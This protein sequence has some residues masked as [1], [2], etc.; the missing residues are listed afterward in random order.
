MLKL[1]DQKISSLYVGNQ[2]IKKAYL[3]SEIVFQEKP[4][5]LPAGY[6]EVEYIQ[7]GSLDKVDLPSVNSSQKVV[8]DVQPLAY[9]KSNE[10]LFYTSVHLSTGYKFFYM[11]RKSATSASITITGMLVKSGIPVTNNGRIII[12][13]DLP[14]KLVK[15]GSNSYSTSAYSLY[16]YGALG[17]GYNGTPSTSSPV[18]PAR[19]YSVKIYNGSELLYDYVPCK[20]PSGKIGMY[21]LITSTFKKG[22][23]G[24]GLTAGPAV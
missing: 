8:M 11:Q 6:T 22:T 19:W 17:L 3:G 13:I 5:R 12:D 14:Q 18:A 9:T 4:S 24:G 20:D 16:G 10:Y 23:N 1:G 7:L 15:I 2:K 21:D